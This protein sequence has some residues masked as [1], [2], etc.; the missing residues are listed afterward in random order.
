MVDLYLPIVHGWCARAGVPRADLADVVQEVFAA[1]CR[2]VDRFR[3]DRPGDS[4]HGWLRG[5]TRHK[6]LDYWRRHPTE[7]HATG[8]TDAQQRLANLREWHDEQSESADLPETSQLV[9]RALD[10]IAIDFEQMTWQAF[11]RT[12]I[13]G[14]APRDVAQDLN[15]TLN[16]VYKAKHRVMRRLRE[17]LGDLI[18]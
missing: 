9:R 16:A 13:D 17:A 2:S 8:G 1:V 3:R 10:L 7:G 18:E 4:F 15:L 6:V 12:S 14:H 11:W 5:I